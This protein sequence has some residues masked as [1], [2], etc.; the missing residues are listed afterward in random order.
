MF[1]SAVRDL[2][3][4]RPVIIRGGCYVAVAFL[5]DFLSRIDPITQKDLANLNWFEWMKIILHGVLASF[6]IIRSFM[7]K[8]LSRHEIQAKSETE[9]RRRSPL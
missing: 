4:W 8:T 5:L 2:V 9:F 3:S 6:L 1:K 7:D